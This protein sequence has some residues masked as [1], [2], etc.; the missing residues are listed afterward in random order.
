YGFGVRQQIFAPLL[1][2]GMFTGD[3]AAW[4]HSRELLRKQFGRAQ[5][6]RLNHCQEHVDNLL[7]SIPQSG[8]VERQP[9]FSSLPL[10]R[11]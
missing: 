2:H 7:A 6:R 4:K 3:G 5:Y 11:T 8:V 1:G 9:L 10:D